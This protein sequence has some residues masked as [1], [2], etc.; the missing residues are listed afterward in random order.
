MRWLHKSP[1][2][3][4]PRPRIQYLAQVFDPDAIQLCEIQAAGPKVSTPVN[5]LLEVSQTAF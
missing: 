4:R 1:L 5:A 3:L 2:R